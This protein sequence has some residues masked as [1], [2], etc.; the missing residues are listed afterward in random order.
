MKTGQVS[1]SAGCI[2]LAAASADTKC[3]QDKNLRTQI[4]TTCTGNH[5]T[6]TL[7]KA[8]AQL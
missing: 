5:A 4:T 6:D 7:Q 8:E 2:C 1:T 3:Q